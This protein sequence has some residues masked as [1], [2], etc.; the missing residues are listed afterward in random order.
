MTLCGFI[1]KELLD[2]RSGVYYLI[3]SND[4]AITCLV[5]PDIVIRYLVLCDQVRHR[6]ALEPVAHLLG[7][8]VLGRHRRIRHV[9][10]PAAAAA[11]L[12]ELRCDSPD[13]RSPSCSD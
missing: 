3:N 7:R 10:R 4:I 9:V 1:K 5:T 12:R 6:G 13:T 8:A 2:I 11:L